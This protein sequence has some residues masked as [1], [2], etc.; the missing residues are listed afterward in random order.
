MER[1]SYHLGQVGHGLLTSIAL[2]V[3]I[4]GERRSRIEGECLL[5]PGKALWIKK[6]A[7][8]GLGALDQI[9]QEHTHQTEDQQSK[10]I[11]RPLLLFFR[12]DSS[13]PIKEPFNGNEYGRKPGPFPSKDLG[14]IQ[15]KRLG[16]QQH[17]N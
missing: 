2:P 15:A 9:Q 8:P 17:H 10:E 16:D 6:A 3:G 11:A 5:N 1:E 7:M 12:V 13:E 4:G 14:Q